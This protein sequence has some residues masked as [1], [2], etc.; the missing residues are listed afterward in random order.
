MLH[1]IYASQKFENT[2]IILLYLISGILKLGKID[3]VLILLYCY[4]ACKWQYTPHRKYIA[5]K[6]ITE[7]NKYAVSS[8]HE[9]ASAQNTLILYHPC[10]SL[11]QLHHLCPCLCMC[12]RAMTFALLRFYVCYLRYQYHQILQQILKPYLSWHKKLC[13]LFTN[14]N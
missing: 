9:A 5:K 14:T 13:V 11:A 2:F 1:Y 3:R 7:K 6:I 8:E 10:T 12:V 4:I